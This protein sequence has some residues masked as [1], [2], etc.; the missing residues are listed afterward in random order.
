MTEQLAKY[1]SVMVDL[2][3]MGTSNNA[4]IVAIGAFK[5]NLNE[6]QDV[7]TIGYN[8]KFYSNVKLASSMRAGLKVDAGA[9]VWWM[10]Q[11]QEVRNHLNLNPISLYDALTAFNS[12]ILP[13]KP[14]LWGNGATFDNVILRSA[15]EPV[16]VEPNWHYKQDMCYRTVKNLFGKDVSFQRIGTQHNA[17]DDAITQ[18]I[19]LQK[20]MEKIRFS[21]K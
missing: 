20:I 17:L 14:M 16:M 15:M 13:G 4:A 12:W 5:F 7:S 21:G 3:T 19:H 9:I 10:D 11:E 18:G 1:D 2:E 6:R 8:Q